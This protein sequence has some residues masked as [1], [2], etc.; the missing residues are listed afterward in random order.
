MKL[1]CNIGQR[2]RKARLVTGGIVDVCGIAGILAGVFGEST[3][4]L[5]TGIFLSIT[6]S[7]MIQTLSRKKSI[8]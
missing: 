3:G 4:F 2:G 7:F 1:A 6:G 5:I 8:V